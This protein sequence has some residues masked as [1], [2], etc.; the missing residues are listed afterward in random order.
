M[1]KEREAD[2]KRLE[3]E[4]WTRIEEL[5]ERLQE[6]LERLETREKPGKVDENLLKIALRDRSRYVTSMRRML[7]DVSSIEDLGRKF[8]EITKFHVS[9][10]RYLLVVFE[11]EMREINSLMK[12][13]SK[14]HAEYLSEVSDLV[15]PELDSEVR[16]LLGELREL[17]REKKGLLRK[18]QEIEERKKKLDTRLSHGRKK[19]NQGEI[20]RVE[21]EVRTLRIQLRSKVSKL[22]KPIKRMRIPE[23]KPFIRDSSFAIDRP[24]EF[25]VLLTNVYPRL[26]GKYKKTARWILENLKREVD[27]L[28]ELE[29]R[30]T[31]LR[32]E[33]ESE[34]RRIRDLQ[35]EIQDMEREAKRIKSDVERLERKEESLR[36]ELMEKAE[37]MGEILGETV[38]VGVEERRPA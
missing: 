32:N 27:R 31:T 24:D 19:G 25:I 12:E 33:K 5:M 36:K 35:R 3:D 34:E 11:K 17:E 38:E 28:N 30:L 13:L 2:I 16:A 14:L 1:R 37:K 8:P 21:R 15:L 9:R 7:S 6:G 22:Q 29:R 23:A 20:E 18:L 4:Y 10:G 26:N